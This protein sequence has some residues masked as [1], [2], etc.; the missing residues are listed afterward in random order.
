MASHEDVS[1]KQLHIAHV[2][3]PRAHWEAVLQTEGYFRRREHELLIY[4]FL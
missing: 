2:E 1:K 3:L 4:V